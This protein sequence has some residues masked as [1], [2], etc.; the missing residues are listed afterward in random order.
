M[1]TG[2]TSDE[3]ADDG[4]QQARA[5]GRQQ[6]Q[7]RRLRPSLVGLATTGGNS[8]SCCAGPWG[9]GRRCQLFQVPDRGQAPDEDR[10]PTGITQGVQAATSAP[11]CCGA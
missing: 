2:C 4:R 5:G 8:R 6:V 1:A 3:G 7:Y 10:T 9:V 11:A